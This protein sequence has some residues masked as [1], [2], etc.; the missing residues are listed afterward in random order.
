MLELVRPFLP[1]KARP[2][3]T[4]TDPVSL[5]VTAHL[6]AGGQPS[7][8]LA[9]AVAGRATAHHVPFDRAA[10][11]LVYEPGA[12]GLR[13]DDLLLVQADSS[14][15]G[16][17]SMDTRSL[18]FRFLLGGRLRPMAIEGW[19]GS[20]WDR[21]WADF[22]FG[23]TPPAAEVDI[24]GV[25]RRSE[26]T[27][28]FVGASS[29]TMRLRDLPLDSLSTRVW[30]ENNLVDVRGFH[31]TQGP[32]SAAGSFS[33]LQKDDSPDVVRLGFDVRSDFPIDALPKV[34]PKE[35]P[36]LIAPFQLQRAPEIHLVGHV[37]G[38]GAAPGLA[39]QQRYVL[40][41]ATSAPMRYQGFPLESLSVRLERRDTDLMLHDIRAGFASGI[42]TGR[43]VLSGPTEES[44]LAF[45]LNLPDAD[46]DQA[47]AAWREFDAARP[48]PSAPAAPD[49]TPDKSPAEEDKPLGGRFS[50]TV[51]AT[52][53]VS[54]PL[55][56]SG[57]GSGRITGS[58]LARIRLLGGFSN[59][60]SSLGIGLTTVELTE[61]EAEFRIE[62]ERLD[63]TRFQLTG[64]SARV[65]SKGSYTMTDGTLDFS[66]KVRPFEKGTG[67]FGSAADF[68][69]SPLT[70]ALEVELRG[71]LEDPE[72]TFSYG[73]TQFFRRIT[74]LQPKPASPPAAP[75]NPPPAKP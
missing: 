73:P 56:Y 13:A 47:I 59:L 46:L 65:E 53:P 71:P 6:A 9:R 20:W 55:A 41:M 18:A 32:W 19:F 24:Q 16:S 63:F 50:L 61:A 48:G 62:R 22:A 45:D 33:R 75:K 27:T 7:R 64:P 39:G 12:H 8:V 69:L 29:G 5:D 4:L 28:V 11:T 2:V 67:F 14:A 49:P 34:F 51:S 44:W 23:P 68:V 74:G 36:G 42:A 21:L 37:F 25:W 43:A 70:N 72:W 26:L 40:D 66:A 31:A 54:D 1:E 58:N 60:L 3:L 30:T 10:A 17:Y 15:R 52:G 57:T 38:S 35:G